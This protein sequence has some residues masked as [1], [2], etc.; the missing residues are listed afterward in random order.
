MMMMMMMMRG[1]VP[2]VPSFEAFF[3]AASDALYYHPEAST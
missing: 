2:A 1:E 3:G